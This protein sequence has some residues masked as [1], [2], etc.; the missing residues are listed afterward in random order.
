MTN[1]GEVVV[2]HVFDYE[3]SEPEH[4]KLFLRTLDQMKEVSKLRKSI[5]YHIGYSNLIFEL[6]MILHKM[7]CKRSLDHRQQYLT[8]LNQTYGTRFASL[9]EYKREGNFD[10]ILQSLTLDD[11][12]KAI[13]RS[14]E[15]M[16]SN[17]ARGFAPQMYKGYRYYMENPSLSL[18]K[19]IKD[20]LSDNGLL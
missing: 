3:S 6:W 17:Q 8:L 18:W 11:V 14:E 15:I 4:Q 19:F 5:K 12:R 13:Q 10:R 2:T 7:D 20:I 16:S 9:G 1:I